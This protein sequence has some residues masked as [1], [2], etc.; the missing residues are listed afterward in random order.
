MAPKHA[1]LIHVDFTENICVTPWALYVDHE[2]KS[3]IISIRGSLSLA[4]VLTDMLAISEDLGK[5]SKYFNFSTEG[6]F[7]HT[8]MWRAA[9]RIKKILDNEKFLESLLLGVNSNSN[10]H[11]LPVCL[12]YNLVVVGHSLGAGTASLL[13]L[14]LLKDWKDVRCFA[15]SCP[16]AVMTEKL[17]KRCEAFI[18]SLVVGKDVVCRVI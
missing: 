16:G 18:V 14:L 2:L 17:S 6:D 12:N 8:G 9:M 4:D 11:T 7:V 10:Y 1:I 13:S 5:H 15:Y 3:V